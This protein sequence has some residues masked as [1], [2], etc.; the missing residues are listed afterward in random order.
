M[1]LRH[2]RYFI[3]LAERLN[4]THAAAQVHVTQST[5]SHQIRQLE[6]ELGQALFQRTKRSVALT[7]AGELFL[8]R[9]VHALGELD[10]AIALLSPASPELTGPGL[11]GDPRHRLLTSAAPCAPCFLRQC[12][13]DFRC[14][15][16]ISP[17]R[18][19]AAVL[20]TLDRESAGW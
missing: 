13:I 10:I 18:V 12:P 3:A 4:F 15:N 7:A 2:L 5:L 14:L 16:G 17:E 9:A 20:E 19:V 1:E 6:E 8:P 11:P